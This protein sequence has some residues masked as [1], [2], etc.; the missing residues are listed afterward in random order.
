MNCHDCYIQG[1]DAEAVGICHHCSVGLCQHH[2]VLLADPVFVQEAITKTTALPKQARQFLCQTCL[3]ALRQR[4]TRVEECG[5]PQS[6][7]TAA[8]PHDAL[9]RR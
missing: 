7:P 1:R 6:G 9:S 2:G 5:L 4:S 3:D 8:S